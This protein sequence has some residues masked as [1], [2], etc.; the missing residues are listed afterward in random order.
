MPQ[1]KGYRD[2]YTASETKKVLGITD[3]KLYNYVRYG[4]LERITPP[5][6]K[7]GVYKK[8]EVDKFALE[9]HAFLS[10]REDTTKEDFKPTTFTKVT[11]DDI[12]DTLRVTEDVFQWRPSKAI[13]TSWVEKNPDVSYQLCKDGLAIGVASML[14]LAPERIERIL[15]GEV[16]S[17]DTLPD[18]IE[19]YK[20]GKPYHLY[21]MGVGVCTSFSK[22]EKRFYGSKLIQ[23]LCEAIIDL[24]R[25][26]I[27]IATISARSHT[28]DGIRIMRHIGFDRIPSITQDVN[29]RVDAQTSDN[30]V[31]LQY[32]EAFLHAVGKAQSCQ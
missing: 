3:G 25:R 26:G 27:E 23:G 9:L 1:N 12:D 16:S 28:V 11:K 29:F 6:R 2:Y 10:T 14:P 31:V 5:G 8:A 30:P 18:E 32:R 21:I 20:A 22:Q 19:R 13:R 24:G 4:H 17:E 7:Q 15:L